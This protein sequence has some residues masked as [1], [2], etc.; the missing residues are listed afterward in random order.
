[1]TQWKEIVER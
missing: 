1:M